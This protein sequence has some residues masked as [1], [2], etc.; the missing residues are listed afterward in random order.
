[1]QYQRGDVHTLGLA[2]EAGS[3]LERHWAA[4]HRVPRRRERA[5]SAT[6]NI[7]AGVL[8]VSSL[9]VYVCGLIFLIHLI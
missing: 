8:L 5:R 3:Y 7:T 1:M 9:G 4:H 2:D 6:W